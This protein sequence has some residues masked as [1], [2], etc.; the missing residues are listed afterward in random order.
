MDLKF[1]KYYNL[2]RQLFVT[3]LKLFYC[4]SIQ[5]DKRSNIMSKKDTMTAKEHIKQF[6]FHYAFEFIQVAEK[7]ISEVIVIE[8]HAIAI[9]MLGKTIDRD[10]DSEKA[11]K[12]IDEQFKAGNLNLNLMEYSQ[13][14]LSQ[15]Q[16]AKR[17]L[18][19]HNIGMAFEVLFKAAILLEHNDFPHKHEL[20]ILYPALGNLKAKFENIII[21]SGWKTVDSFTTYLDN[22]FTDPNNKYFETYLTFNDEH[23]HPKALINLFKKLSEHVTKYANENN[24]K[25][26]SDWSYPIR[27]L[28]K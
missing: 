24:I 28:S 16:M 4:V 14:S 3:R 10:R 15:L 20:S 19:Y 11:Q 6:G 27:L 18:A 5:Y 8:K 25:R 21:A 23:E 12:Y 9:D 1:K 22:Y 13:D 2:V 17:Y 26:P 7:N